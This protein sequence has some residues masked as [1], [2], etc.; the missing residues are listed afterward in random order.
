MED[1]EVPAKPYRPDA[2]SGERSLSSET[3][4]AK[5]F[6][7][8]QR[9]LNEV[10]AGILEKSWI[11]ELRTDVA[12]PQCMVVIRSVAF[13]WN[14]IRIIG[15]IIVVVVVVRF[16]LKRKR[17]ANHA[18]EED[19]FKA[20]AE[21]ARAV[22]A[23]NN[24]RTKYKH[25]LE[26]EQTRIDEQIVDIVNEMDKNVFELFETKSKYDAAIKQESLKITRLSKA[27]DDDDRQKQRIRLREW[28]PRTR[29]GT[30]FFEI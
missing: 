15:R 28:V 29:A 6:R 17:R 7:F 21:Y 24:E 14:A 11:E 26:D 8:K 20:M 3:A 2:S 10:L 5:R 18:E 23:K 19:D 16:Q 4:S 12:K 27:L 9:V 1:H 22:A 25:T 13:F 30:V